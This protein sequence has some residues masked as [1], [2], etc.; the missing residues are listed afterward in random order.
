[1]K[2]SWVIAGVFFI[3]SIICLAWSVHHG[4][5]GYQFLFLFGILFWWLSEHPRV[6]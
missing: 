4:V 1:M 6:P 5:W 3:L 2:I